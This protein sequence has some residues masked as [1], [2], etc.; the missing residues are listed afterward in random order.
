MQ[1]LGYTVFS[2]VCA[3]YLPCGV[4]MVI[5]AKVFQAA[6]ARIHKKRFRSKPQQ[7][8]DD[9]RQQ[10]QHHE[11][12]ADAGVD[13]GPIVSSASDGNLQASPDDVGGDITHTRTHTHTHT[14][15]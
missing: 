14:S 8:H 7:H 9:E 6:R 15:V 10:Q 3:F 1:D 4:M 5:Y 12:D 11:F 2:T 13:A